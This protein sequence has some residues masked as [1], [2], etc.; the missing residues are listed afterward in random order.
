MSLNLTITY[1]ISAGSGQR[2][3]E[4][5]IVLTKRN[6]CFIGKYKKQFIKTENVLDVI[7]ALQLVLCKK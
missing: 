5:K 1:I 7:S 6:R 2:E 3:L 4:D